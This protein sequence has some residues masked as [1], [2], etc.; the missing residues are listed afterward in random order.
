MC[1]KIHYLHS[2]LD[3]FLAN[4]GDVSEEQGEHFH[5]DIKTMLSRLMGLEHNGSLLLELDE[6]T[7]K[8]YKRD[9]LRKGSLNRQHFPLICASFLFLY[10]NFLSVN[11]IK[12]T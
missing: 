8:L 9:H 6:T 7:Q 12:Y 1:I 4:L 10:F 11:Y 3:K 5:Q 2:N